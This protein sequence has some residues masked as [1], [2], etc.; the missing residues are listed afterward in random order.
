[1]LLEVD[2]IASKAVK[3]WVEPAPMAPAVVAVARARMKEYLRVRGATGTRGVEKVDRIGVRDLKIFQSAGAGYVGKYRIIRVN[4]K[5][6]KPDS[7]LYC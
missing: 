7:S 2:A 6:S 4:L 1:M 3:P 5:I